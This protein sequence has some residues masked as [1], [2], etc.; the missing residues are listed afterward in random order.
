M[1]DPTPPVEDQ[2]EKEAEEDHISLGSESGGD[3]EDGGTKSG[4]SQITPV[5]VTLDR[6]TKKKQREQ[7]TY[8]DI[9][10]GSQ[11]TL[12]GMINSRSTIKQGQAPKG[13]TTSQA[14]K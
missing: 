13:A 9:L 10:Q 3:S 7:K 4:N 2:R 14:S 6:K 8:L 12:K 1:A 5:K 11:K